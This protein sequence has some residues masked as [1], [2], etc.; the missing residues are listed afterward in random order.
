M[1]LHSGRRGGDDGRRFRRG[2]LP[3]RGH[4]RAL[5]MTGPW[6]RN[7]GFGAESFC[8]HAESRELP[9]W[10]T[11]H[12]VIKKLPEIGQTLRFLILLAEPGS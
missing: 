5:R 7:G 4:R 9:S 2:G 10:L 1:D 3:C 12:I 6:W 11:G 8:L